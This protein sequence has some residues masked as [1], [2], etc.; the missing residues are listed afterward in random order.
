MHLKVYINI[1][2]LYIILYKEL[3]SLGEEEK[4]EKKKEK[5]NLIIFML[6]KLSVFLKEKT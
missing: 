1:L 6:S 3:N 5:E 4:Q 2:I